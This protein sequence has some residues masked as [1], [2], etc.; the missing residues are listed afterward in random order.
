MF[1][2][3]GRKRSPKAAS[4]AVGRPTGTCSSTALAG[5]HPNPA[6]AADGERLHVLAPD[7]QTAD[8]VRRIF[9]DY[10]AGRGVKAIAEALTADGIPSP[11]AYDP[12]RNPHRCGIAWSWGAVTAILGNPRYTG[13]QVW[14]R[15]RKDE[16]LLDVQDVALGFTTKQ[17][18]N[19]R[20]DWIWSEQT[21]HEPLIDT[22]TFEQAQ[23][24]RRTRASHAQRAPRR[25]RAR[26]RCAGCSTRDL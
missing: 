3:S 9:A 8:V 21:V 11:S 12:A 5:L 7:P 6:K 4:L 22:A 1:A 26:T 19:Q 10:L 13:R 2:T 16:V 25:T 20:A 18:W 15:Q 23:A 14:N 24:L 17:R